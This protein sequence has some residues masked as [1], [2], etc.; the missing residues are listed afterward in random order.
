M[1]KKLDEFIQKYLD[2]DNKVPKEHKRAVA[3]GLKNEFK[4]EFFNDYRAELL[5][6][7]QEVN[8]EKANEIALRRFSEK[9]K[10]LKNT[11][12]NVILISFLMGML[13][14]QTTDLLT[15]F[16]ISY[17]TTRLPWTFGFIVLF[18]ILVIGAVHFMYTNA[19]EEFTQTMFKEKGKKYE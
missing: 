18:L 10:V 2:A 19:I 12:I 1:G 8:Q 9:L 17:E 11:T 7:E 13:I 3:E 6:I 15:Y 16:K 4:K 14:N 5:A